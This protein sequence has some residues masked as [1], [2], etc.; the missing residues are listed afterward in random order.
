MN[1][2][3]SER[4]RERVG[5]ADGGQHPLRSPSTLRSTSVPLP[6]ALFV[7]SWLTS[8]Y[9][10]FLGRF[11]GKQPLPFKDLGDP[12]LQVRGLEAMGLVPLLGLWGL[13]PMWKG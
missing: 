8:P 2:A 7:V 10:G 13:L 4:E 12:L 3:E 11:Q 5:Q 1:A 9:K 6:H